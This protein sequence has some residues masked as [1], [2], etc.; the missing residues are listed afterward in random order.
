MP[1]NLDH[2]ATT[3]LL[4]AA[5][6]AMIAALDVWANPSSPHVAGRRAK[7]M[8][9]DARARVAAALGWDGAVIFTASAS[10]ALMLAIDGVKRARRMASVTE[11]DAVLRHIG[12]GDRLP[13]DDDG[14]VCHADLDP[15][16]AL[17]AVQSVNSE[18]GV[19]QPVG[20]IA[21]TVRAAGGLVLSDCAQSAG[22]LP[23]P[24]ADLIVVSAHKIGG[25]VGAAALLVRDLGVLAAGGGQELGYRAGTENL[26]AI[27]GFAAAMEADRSWLADAAI[28]RRRVDAAIAETGG[29]VVARSVSRIPTIASYRMPGVSARAQLIRFDAAGIAV[30]AGSACSS[31]TL[32]TSHVLR[33]MGWADGPAAE[34][35]RVS[36]GWSTTGQHVDSFI[37]QWQRIA[38]G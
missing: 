15:G 10:E 3:P 13:V 6:D 37:D 12:E 31:G 26:P 4:P 20:D 23:L 8:L 1:I 32:R 22:K 30:S 19:I 34:V 9:E 16:H 5:R 35:I 17:V 18:T 24:D 14:I 28:F 38:Q 25:P 29:D 11:H 7:A 36:F 2:A 21:A 33:A 27:M